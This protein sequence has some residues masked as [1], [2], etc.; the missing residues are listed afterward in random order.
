LIKKAVIVA[1]GCSSRLY[2][3]TLDFP[4]PLLPLRNKTLLEQSVE[5]LQTFGVQSIAVVIG[6][7]SEQIRG[8][9]SGYGEGIHFVENPFYAHCNNMGSLWFAREFI[10][11]ERFLYLHGDIAYSPTI[12]EPLLHDSSEGTLGRMLVDYGPTDEESMKVKVDANQNL[13]A[14]S[15]EIP[16]KEAAGEWTGIAEFSE[17][18]LVFDMFDR[19][20]MAGKL[21]CYDTAAFTELCK[22]HKIQC[23]DV[24]GLPWIEIDFES[25][26]QRAMKLFP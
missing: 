3:R 12:L 26:Y 13:V 20:L 18:D 17:P 7:K 8:A 9:L 10:G 25:D 19:F 11:R 24:N 14:S 22:L 4:K 23:P 2:P 5:H 1:A 15:K 21:N 16:F 6:Y